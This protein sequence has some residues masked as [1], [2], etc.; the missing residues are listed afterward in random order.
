MGRPKP[1]WPEDTAAS[2]GEAR[3]HR[4]GAV[5]LKYVGQGSS[6]ADIPA[7]DLSSAELDDLAVTAAPLLLGH[8]G[9][10]SLV[11]A[12]LSSGLYEE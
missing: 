4:D 7:R 12:L 9:R 5:G 8:G 1:V 6:L 10:K 2:S 3:G 11:K